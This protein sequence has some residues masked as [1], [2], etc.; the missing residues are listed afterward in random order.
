MGVED[1]KTGESS[2]VGVDLYL[3]YTSRGDWLSRDKLDGF[4]SGAL[5]GTGF[6]CGRI[7]SR[8]FGGGCGEGDT[9]DSG[10]WS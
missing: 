7:G 4:F 10:D 6:V 8:D 9:G 1:I 3:E 2:Y 5:Y